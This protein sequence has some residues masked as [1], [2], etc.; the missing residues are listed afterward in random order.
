MK[1]TSAVLTPR[2]R[3][4]E[5]HTRGQSLSGAWKA[6]ELL[7][8]RLVQAKARA[9]TAQTWR[10]SSRQKQGD[11]R[12]G[13]RREITW[14][15]SANKQWSLKPSLRRQASL[16]TE[17]ANRRNGKA[18][19]QE[20]EKARCWNAPGRHFIRR[21]T[22][23]SELNRKGRRTGSQGLKSWRALGKSELTANWKYRRRACDEDVKRTGGWGRRGSLGLEQGTEETETTTMRLCSWKSRRAEAPENTHQGGETTPGWCERTQ[24]PPAI[25]D[26]V[27]SRGVRRRGGAPATS[28]QLL[29]KRCPFPNTHQWPHS[30]PSG[31]FSVYI[32]NP[33]LMKRFCD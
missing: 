1:E 3:P 24:Q 13:G 28:I 4:S 2:A 29:D 20:T 22:S 17:T 30:P 12:N 10:T 14:I 8:A 33:C 32:S 6:R 18:E 16:E 5:G 23:G 27:Y 9:P 31:L 11:W 7:R 19:R 21:L 25:G 26:R 15:C